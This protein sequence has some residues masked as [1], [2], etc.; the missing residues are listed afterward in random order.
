MPPTPARFAPA[1][2]QYISGPYVKSTV[3]AECEAQYGTWEGVSFSSFTSN[4]SITGPITGTVAASG[5]ECRANSGPWRID[6]STPATVKGGIANLLTGVSASQITHVVDESNPDAW[7]LRMQIEVQPTP[8]IGTDIA[9][10]TTTQLSNLFGLSVTGIDL[11]EVFIGFPSPSP[12]PP[13]PPPP[14]APLPIAPPLQPPP[15][16]APSPVSPP[17]GYLSPTIDVT[18]NI[19]RGTWTNIASGKCAGG[20]STYVWSA[21]NVWTSRQSCQNNCHWV[22][23]CAGFAWQETSQT[24][25]MVSRA[26]PRPPRPHARRLPPPLLP[27][28]AHMPPTCRPHLLAL[29]LRRHSISAARM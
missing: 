25:Y 14:I 8:Q 2:P 16:A 21:N 23:R 28:S 6:D 1:P 9:A 7:T 10:I 24:C 11:G 22:N 15:P 20:L 13:T 12:P 4:P 17:P 3:E 18:A 5:W 26:L 27:T 29:P 19:K